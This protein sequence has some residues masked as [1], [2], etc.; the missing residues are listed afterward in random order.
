MGTRQQLVAGEHLKFVGDHLEA[1]DEALKQIDRSKMSPS[2]VFAMQG[3]HA[4]F[5]AEKILPRDEDPF[6]VAQIGTAA[7]AVLEDLMV[8]PPEERTERNAMTILLS[9]A[10]KEFP[11]DED[12]QEHPDQGRWKT[13]VWDKVKGLWSIENPA[14][15]EVVA[16]EWKLDNVSIDGI[17]FIGYIDRTDRNEDGTL[18]VLDYKSGKGKG[19]DREGRRKLQRFGDDHGDQIRF[20]K[21]AL[22]ALSGEEVGSGSV[23]Y[24]GEGQQR[25]IGFNNADLDRVRRMYGESWRELKADVA[26]GA[27]PTKPGPLCSWCPLVELCP[28]AALG[29]YKAKVDVPTAEELAIPV[30]SRPVSPSHTQGDPYFDPTL[31]DDDMAN[32][33]D[34]DFDPFEAFADSPTETDDQPEPEPAPRRRPAREQAKARP[35]RRK[36]EPEPEYDDEL[37]EVDEVEPEPE[38]ARPARP[39]PLFGEDKSWYATA[40]GLPNGN[41]FGAIGAFGMVELAISQIS[42]NKNTSGRMGIASI[43]ALAR[44]FALI[45]A[46][47]QEYLSGSRDPHAGLATRMRGA[48]RTT[49][50]VMPAPLGQPFEV[51]QEWRDKT[52]RRCIVLGK[53]A[54]TLLTDLDGDDEPYAILASDASD[55]AA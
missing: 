1:S 15:I 48:L 47:A 32:D 10:D 30:E 17:P 51:W 33:F 46:D 22:E 43:E 6:G 40:E 26:A 12:G 14:E 24:I 37:D 44:T 52:T 53:V 39:A 49:L 13:A 50:E 20:Y 3:C 36:P 16:T 23:Y 34:P 27:F 38:P 25:E 5:A 45:V 18:R 9:N 31:E 54:Y 2:T 41:A 42:S 28:S 19:L 8:L 55:I 4:R 7:H 29:G 21:L 11:P 35:A